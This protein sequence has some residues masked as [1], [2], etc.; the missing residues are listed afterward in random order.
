MN[1]EEKQ[2]LA[3]EAAEL[4]NHL[5]KWLGHNWRLETWQKKY[6]ARIQKYGLERCKIAVDGFCSMNW[7]VQEKG[8]EAPEMIF[9]SDKFFERFLAAGEKLFRH[10]PETRERE[11]KEA[12]KA[13][14]MAK[15]RARLE[16]KNAD[17]TARMHRKFAELRDSGDLNI[18]DRSWT[19]SLAPL[20]CVAYERGV[21]ILFSEDAGWVMDNYLAQ[22]ERALGVRVRV[23]D[24]VVEERKAGE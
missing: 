18:C 5:R 2:R 7:W 3:A 9:R 1:D 8:T 12:E 13:A 21:L 14:R 16:A 22:L 11:R 23:V 6:E 15:T 24:E 17:M 10:L 19:A 4:H 20:L